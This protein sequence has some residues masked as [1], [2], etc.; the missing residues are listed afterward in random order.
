MNTTVPNRLPR[1]TRLGVKMLIEDKL[2]ELSRLTTLSSWETTFITDITNRLKNQ[3][4]ISAKAEKKVEEIYE[5]KCGVSVGKK[6][7]VSGCEYC[8]LNG[9][10][11]P[12]EKDGTMWSAHCDHNPPIEVISYKDVHPKEYIEAVPAEFQENVLQPPDDDVIPF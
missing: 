7:V 3:L 10:R 11:H 9:M 2:A 5:E 8:D 12:W 1:N 6:K 4:L